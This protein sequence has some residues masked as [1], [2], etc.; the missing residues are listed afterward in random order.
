M[1]RSTSFPTHWEVVRLGDAAEVQT[2]RAMSRTNGSS[3]L[4]TV[5]YL[6]VANVK[7]GYLDLSNVKAMQ[8]APAE[9]G[10]YSLRK[11]DVLFTEGGDA[12]KLGRGC[13]W[14]GQIEPC[15]H[16]NHVF[17]V[18]PDP[19][20]L[21]PEFLSAYAQSRAGKAYFLSCAK[22][23]TNLAS[24]NSTQ[25]KAMP[26]PLPP[27]PEQERIVETLHGVDAAIKGTERL[28][29]SVQKLCTALL[30]QLL[31]RGV[32]GWHSEWKRVPGVGMMPSCWDVVRLGE[33]YEVQLGKMLS[34]K[35]KSGL[36][37]KPYLTNRNVRWG[38]FDLSDVPEMDFDEREFIKFSLKPGDLLVC[39]GGEVGRAAI[40]RAEIDGC[41]Y[42]KALRRLRPRD[43]SSVPEFLLGFM[44]LAAS[45]GLLVEHTTQTSIAHLTAEKL[46]KLRVP[47]PPAQEQHQIV[48]ILTMIDRR[49]ASE[50][51]VLGQLSCLRTRT[52]ESLLSS[53][54]N[55]VLANTSASTGF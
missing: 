2:G 5:P 32:S 52:S 19:Q 15:L 53:R 37:S 48:E 39:E 50:K 1:N 22:Q 12:D 8:V 30:Q 45:S 27:L 13:I 10:R 11:G 49:S 33:V 9:I 28:I 36:N 34:Q 26:L 23:T 20:R 3:D 46:V 51:Q 16:Q 42:Q 55:T 43:S 18:R 24:I 6:T 17:A 25:L 4:I 41:C 38:G 54:V 21:R 7:D 40:W 31:A 44:R 47:W 35:S 14:D 29:D